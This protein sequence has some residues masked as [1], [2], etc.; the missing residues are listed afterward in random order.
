[1]LVRE[2]SRLQAEN[3]QRLELMTGE[4]HRLVDDGDLERI[5][6]LNTAISG[7]VTER[8]VIRKTPTWPWSPGAFGVLTSAVLL[9][10]VVWLLQQLLER[11]LSP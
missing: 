7:L 2:K 8:E 11:V 1:M 10:I 5:S 9:P 6:K 3:D 4:L